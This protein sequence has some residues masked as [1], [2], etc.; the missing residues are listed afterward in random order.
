MVIRC[1]RFA[2]D[3]FGKTYKQTIGVDFFMKRIELP[4]P[5]VTLLQCWDIGGQVSRVLI[6]ELRLLGYYIL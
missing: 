5:V 3:T 1:C 6:H 2:S 4:G